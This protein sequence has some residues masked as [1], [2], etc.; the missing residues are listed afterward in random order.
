MPNILACTSS[1][2]RRAGVERKL[3]VALTLI[4]CLSGDAATFNVSKLTQM[5]GTR[6]SQ[7]LERHV[8]SFQFPREDKRL[9]YSYFGHYRED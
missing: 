6:K 8:F 7:R 3:K 4:A 1:G 9:H 2:E 5:S